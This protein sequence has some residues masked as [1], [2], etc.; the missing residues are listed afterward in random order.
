M[1]TVYGSVRYTCS[2]MSRDQSSF[3]LC[4]HIESPKRMQRNTYL[5][6]YKWLLIV[7][8]TSKSLQVTFCSFSCIVVL[9]TCSNQVHLPYLCTSIYLCDWASLSSRRFLCTT[10]HYKYALLQHVPSYCRSVRSVCNGML[11]GC[12]GWLLFRIYIQKYFGQNNSVCLNRLF[13]WVVC[14]ALTAT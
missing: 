10:A 7:L 2:A 5:L 13:G 9:C 12:V 14:A 1:Y 11:D 6:L 3:A 8:W 4:E